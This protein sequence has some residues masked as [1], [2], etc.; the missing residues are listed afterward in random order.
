MNEPASYNEDSIRELS[1]SLRALALDLVRDSSTADDLVQD[2]WVAW[3]EARRE[4][5]RSLSR[6]MRAVVRHGA[7]RTSRKATL[8]GDHERLAAEE[9]ES[10]EHEF[11][12]W[13][14]SAHLL[15]DAIAEL[16]EPYRDVLRARYFDE[17]TVEQVATR[18]EVPTNTVKTW[19]RRGLARLREILDRRT[20]GDRSSWAIALAPL[21]SGGRRSLGASAA[22]SPVIWW[23]LAASTAVLGLVAWMLSGD[24]PDL[25]AEEALAQVESPSESEGLPEPTVDLDAETESSQRLS[26]E[27]AKLE[28]NEVSAPQLSLGQLEVTVVDHLGQVVPGATVHARGIK[29][30]SLGAGETDSRGVI[31]L[32]ID[33]DLIEPVI[34]N[35]S[36]KGVV[37]LHALAS[38]HALGD[39]HFVPL[40]PGEVRH[41]KVSL[42]G[43]GKRYKGRLVDEFG[44]PVE[45]AR[46]L[47]LQLTRSS[48]VNEE[49]VV[50]KPSQRIVFSD[51]EGSFV[52]DSLD[53][54]TIGALVSAA[55]FV[56]QQI[57]INHDSSDENVETVYELDRGGGISGILHNAD[58]TPA[59]HARV[60][61]TYLPNR[62]SA[63]VMI[64]ADET[65]WFALQGVPRYYFL[66]RA[67]S[68][69]NPELVASSVID[70]SQSADIQWDATLEPLD[71]IRVR[72]LS[73]N[74]DAAEGCV[75]ILGVGLGGRDWIERRRTDSNG[76]AVF[77]QFPPG[78][79]QLRVYE[80]N[81]IQTGKLLA[82]ASNVVAS[83]AVYVF[84][85]EEE[86]IVETSGVALTPQLA[87]GIDPKDVRMFA[88]DLSWGGGQWG[89]WNPETGRI[90]LEDL[91]PGDYSLHLLLPDHGAQKLG[92]KTL[93][94]G[95]TLDLGIVVQ[96]NTVSVVV[97][98]W[99]G[100]SLD[101]LELRYHV[102]DPIRSSL[103][104]P[105]PPNAE[106]IVRAT[107][108]AVRLFDPEEGLA[109]ELIPGDYALRY[110]S[111]DNAPTVAFTV[112]PGE[113]L[114]IDPQ[115]TRNK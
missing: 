77:T 1:R 45:R 74:G 29:S 66:I 99:P 57:P 62:S 27:A 91:A 68:G 83:D 54:N 14:S 35:P 39:G 69:Q 60:F 89:T 6:W 87:K 105:V 63:E 33:T 84:H 7:I 114:V 4:G 38:D 113:A 15:I 37:E 32:S 64:Q 23:T 10:V 90:E 48:F 18:F 34:G 115:A 58:G 106:G 53:E 110:G 49:G 17:C 3:L 43:P 46:V 25:P 88:R 13:R 52:L 98:P 80:P 41:V 24:G 30:V 31:S 75:L 102:E 12:E 47:A 70:G 71:P 92:R 55:G 104:G 109:L 22:I 16:E 78:G 111:Q 8:R 20:G 86:P 96:A 42:R 108:A 9:G 44:D 5:V 101:S 28:V 61:L 79:L 95:E 59:K 19:T 2:A 81:Y 93:L 56:P 36:S 65:G 73:A 26:V 85:L 21:T 11:G 50:V 72:V 67:V 100:C 112:H 82:S 76:E 40:G 103:E 97:S 94:A 107:G 51:A